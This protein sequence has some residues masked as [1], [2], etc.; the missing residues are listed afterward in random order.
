MTSSARASTDGG[1]VSPRAFAVLR[2]IT[3]LE[4]CGL[5]STGRS[6]GFA[7][8]VG[9]GGRSPSVR[10]AGLSPAPIVTAASAPSKIPDGGFPQYGFK[11]WRLAITSPLPV[12]RTGIKR[13]V[14][15]P[16][17][18]PQFEGL[19]RAWPSCHYGWFSQPTQPQVFVTTTTPTGPWLRTGY[20]VPFLLATATRS[21]SLADSRC[22]PRIA[23]YTARSLPDNLVWAARETF[24]ALGQ[25]SFLTCRHPYA[26]R[27]SEVPQSPPP[28]PWPSSTEH[29][30]GSSISPTPAAVGCATRSQQCSL[31]LRPAKLLALLDW[32]DLETS[33]AAEDVY[34]SLPEAGHPN[35]ESGITTQPSWG[36]TVT[37]LSPAGVLP[38]QAALGSPWL[39][40]P[41]PAS[42]PCR[43]AVSRFQLP[44]RRT[45]R[46][47]F[48]HTA[49]LAL[50]QGLC[51]LSSGSA[52]R[53]GLDPDPVVSKQPK[54]VVQPRPTPPLPAEALSLPRSHQMSPHLLLDP[55]SRSQ[56][57]GSRARSGSS[58]P[59][60]ARS[61]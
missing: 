55:V 9:S 24:P 12:D 43:F 26:E 4:L 8:T 44:P 28:C 47:A 27:R 52:F 56:S 42:C 53:H 17:A 20:V 30:V 33:P 15:M 29:G 25:C 10:G 19:R 40:P 7:P 14:C 32:S 22:F 60:L 61:G 31:M 46:A 39:Y 13:Q 41:F 49:L 45:V 51:D 18:A 6:A 59:S 36:R 5:S 37:G 23:G 38:L 57:T 50:R 58:S 21:A 54:P 34:P 48:P 11:P 35:P 3:T 16:P 1:I 2:L